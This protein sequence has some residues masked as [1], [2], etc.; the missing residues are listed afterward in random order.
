M[1]RVTVKLP[2]SYFTIRMDRQ[3]MQ[4][5]DGRNQ[6]EL[7]FL[8]N[9]KT[10]SEK[11]RKN[12]LKGTRGSGSVATSSTKN[13]RK[14]QLQSTDTYF[15]PLKETQF[16]IH[17]P[18]FR[19]DM[20]KEAQ[21]SKASSSDADVL[22]QST[23]PCREQ[24][25]IDACSYAAKGDTKRLLALLDS[26]P[27][28]LRCHHHKTGK[29][30]LHFSAQSGNREVC[31]LLIQSGI[32]PYARDAHGKRVIWPGKSFAYNNSRPGDKKF[33]YM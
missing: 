12:I 30:L 13:I 16:S 33:T 2:H 7:V 26:R 15:K 21:S 1:E 27:H 9:D 29:T 32:S 18:S 6:R 19:N 3:N 8:Y 24:E 17:A 23:H 5:H 11:L 20:V 10:E 28:L 22:F 31:E 14:F 4:Q 25:F